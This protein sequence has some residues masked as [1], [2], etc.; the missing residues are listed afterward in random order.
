MLK[1]ILKDSKV[2]D[3]RYKIMRHLQETDLVGKTIARLDTTAVNHV[4]IFF[5][6]GT[7]VGLWAEDAVMT[8]YGNI[9]GIF[10]EDSTEDSEEVQ[11][12]QDEISEETPESIE[13][14]YLEMANE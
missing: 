14:N 6:D 12:V 2:A 13:K 11:E 9:P 7:S 5:T 8:Q 4:T 3:W 1:D 10:I